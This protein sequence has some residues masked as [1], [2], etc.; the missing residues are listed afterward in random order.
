MP[1]EIRVSAAA[2]SADTAVKKKSGA[3][4]HSA[5]VTVCLSKRA[6]TSV[7]AASV[8]RYPAFFAKTHNSGSVMKPFISSSVLFAGI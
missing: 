7:P 6:A 1:A 5:V 8:N 4:R 3:S 2:D